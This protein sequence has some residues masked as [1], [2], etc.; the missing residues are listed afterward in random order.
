M[1]SGTLGVDKAPLSQD[2]C[3][4]GMAS[5]GLAKL[6][7]NADWLLEPPLFLHP[8]GLPVL[9][10]AQSTLGRAGQPRGMLCVVLPGELP[11]APLGA[12]LL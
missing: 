6:L 8:V 12:W 11:Q 10:I 1:R 5:D 3:H 4:E 7:R 2:S 9:C